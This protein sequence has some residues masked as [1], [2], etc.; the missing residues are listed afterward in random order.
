MDNSRRKF[1]KITSGVTTGF[2]LSGLSGLSY[3]SSCEE[4]GKPKLLSPIKASPESLRRIRLY[5][6]NM[7]GIFRCEDKGK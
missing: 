3:F 1:I 5:L 7:G 6:G 4:T 2:A